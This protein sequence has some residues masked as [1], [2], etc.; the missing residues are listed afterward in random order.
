[1]W[2]TL[3]LLLTI[4][5]LCYTNAQDDGLFRKTRIVGGQDAKKGAFPF[6][7]Y[8]VDEENRLGCAGTLISPRIILTAGHCREAA[9]RTARV[10]VYDSSSPFERGSEE[11]S[12]ALEVIHPQYNNETIQNDLMLLLLDEPIPNI[13]TISLFRPSSNISGLPALFSHELKS[14]QPLYTMGWGLTS[15]GVNSKVLQIVE[16]DYITNEACKSAKGVDITTMEEVDYNDL[17]YNDMLCTHYEGRKPR[18]A[19]AG[20]SGGPLVLIDRKSFSLVQVGVTSWGLACGDPV[21]PGVSSRIDDLSFESFIRPTVCHLDED[22]PGDFACEDLSSAA[23]TQILVGALAPTSTPT[24]LSPEPSQN[25]SFIPS[26]LP[27]LAPSGSPSHILKGGLPS[28]ESPSQNP[29]F[30]PSDMPSLAPSGTPSLIPSDSPS[31]IVFGGSISSESPSQNPSFV[32]SDMPSLAPSGAPSHIPSDLPSLAPSGVQP[33]QPSTP[34]AK[35][36]PKGSNDSPGP[37]MPVKG[38]FESFVPSDMPSLAPSGAS[39]Y[40]PSDLPSLAPSRASSFIPSDLPSLAPSG[41]Q[42]QEASLG[43]SPI[44]APPPK[45]DPK[46]PNGSL[47]PKMPPKGTRARAST[48]PS[49]SPT[50]DI[51]GALAA[52]GYVLPIDLSNHQFNSA[53]DEENNGSRFLRA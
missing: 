26:D 52:E 43:P 38:G 6:V 9:L 37:K 13:P 14:G 1:M 33:Q 21:F 48:I 51:M 41:A 35:K 40:I 2:R 49:A 15:E 25:P 16:L 34:P 23:P 27:S 50:R 17:I 47:G 7:A 22:A 44:G 18:D 11:R 12:I 30:V 24:T 5:Q 53:N 45:K 19:C 8:L 36:D 32:P 31:H 3:P 39:S 46:G 28:D 42:T 20:D 29:S 10:G 4:A